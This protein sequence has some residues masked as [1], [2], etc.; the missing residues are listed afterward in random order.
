MYLITVW[1]AAHHSGCQFR[2]PPSDSHLPLQPVLCRHLLHLHHYPNVAETNTRKTKHHT[3][4]VREL[5][6]IKPA[7]PEELTLQAL[8]PEQK[9]YRVFIHREA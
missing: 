2:L 6:F 3:Q 1:K 9:G 5:S 8:S 4:R 7:D